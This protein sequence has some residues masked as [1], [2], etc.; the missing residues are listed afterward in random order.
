[1]YQ[2]SQ[3]NYLKNQVTSA[4]PNKLIE[5]LLEGAIKR[6]RMGKLAI[7]NNNIVQASEQIIRAQ[8]IIMELRYSINE[9]VDSQIPQDLIQLYEFMYDRL[10]I[11]NM[12][13]NTAILDEV[14]HLIAELT[15]AWKQISTNN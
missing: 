3:D 11:A 14:Q 8:D 2:N 10:V 4:S 1:M 6:I 9:E 5:M 12:E 13:K 7:E 15:D